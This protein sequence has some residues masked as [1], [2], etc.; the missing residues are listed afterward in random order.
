MGCHDGAQPAVVHQGR[1]AHGHRGVLHPACRRDRGPPLA[2]PLSDC[3][4]CGGARKVGHASATPEIPPAALQSKHAA[5]MARPP[6][7]WQPAARCLTHRSKQGQNAAA[8]RRRRRH[9]TAQAPR[10]P[11]MRVR[12]NTSPRPWRATA[13]ARRRRRAGAARARTRSALGGRALGGPPN[14]T[15][16]RGKHPPSPDPREVH[17]HPSP[18]LDPY[19]P[20]TAP[21]RA[22]TMAHSLRSFFRAA[23]C[24]GAAAVRAPAGA[25]APCMAHGQGAAVG[26]AARRS[27]P[28]PVPAGARH[29]SSCAPAGPSFEPREPD[30]SRPFARAPAASGSPRPA[31]LPARA[32][33]RGERCRAGPSS[34]PLA[35]PRNAQPET[36]HTPNPR[37]M[38]TLARPGP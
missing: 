15:P 5:P 1:R 3:G 20:H 34:P 24:T 11:A 12:P 16:R 22:A 37:P 2:Q 23:A 14:K 8:P 29:A 4:P 13:R 30:G 7:C 26:A 21:K 18:S 32:P 19:P 27:P 17:R 38:T 31:V 9:R 35:P 33:R 6:P 25:A 10:Q 36:L 28:R